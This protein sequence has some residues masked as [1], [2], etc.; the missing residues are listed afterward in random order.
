MNVLEF[1]GQA[2]VT[3]L[4]FAFAFSSLYLLLTLLA[5]RGAGKSRKA[6]C[7]YSLSRLRASEDLRAGFEADW[8][9]LSFTKK[10][11][12]RTFLRTVDCFA[13]SW[14]QAERGQRG[15]SRHHRYP[16]CYRIV[17]TSTK[18][19]YF[20]SLSWT[21]LANQCKGQPVPNGHLSS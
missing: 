8:S 1:S 20:A 4:T 15:R 11:G 13:G 7:S 21:S 12:K 2:C 9:R 16:G 6:K 18:C 17:S 3:G 5:K 19:L 14:R 10:G